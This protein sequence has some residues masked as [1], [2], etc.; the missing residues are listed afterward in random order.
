MSFYGTHIFPRLMDWVMSGSEFGRLRTNLLS[1]V[2]GEV[3]EIG[4]GTGL[5]L[6]YYPPTLSRLSA[7]DPAT[8]LPRLVARRIAAVP[9]PVEQYREPAERLPFIDRRFDWVV[10]TWT[11]CSI[12]DPL[13]ALAEVRRVLKPGGRFRFLEHGRS[14]DP[15]TV[16]WQDRLNPI[17]NVIGC[18]C[19]LNRPIDELIGRSGFRVVSLERFH[20]DHV[21]RV[22]GEMYRGAAEVVLSD[23]T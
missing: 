8:A 17:Q 14:A 7:V 9:F 23:G 11:L 5:N 10:S 22:A 16:A 1:E 2:Q 18:G 20:M 19:H 15:R 13:R 3:L 12:A 21:P 6:L 4:F